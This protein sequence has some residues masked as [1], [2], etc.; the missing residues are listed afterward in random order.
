MVLQSNWKAD[1]ISKDH[2]THLSVTGLAGL[3]VHVCTHSVIIPLV[4]KH[5]TVEFE[6]SP[7]QCVSWFR[8]PFCWWLNGWMYSTREDLHAERWVCVCGVYMCV[9]VKWLQPGPVDVTRDDVLNC[10]IF[11]FVDVAAVFHLFPPE[12]LDQLLLLPLVLMR[13]R[14][15]RTHTQSSFKIY[16]TV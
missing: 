8:I 13:W 1:K 2:Q 14:L 15:R 9:C 3:S 16:S 11:A 10:S 12:L 7:S 4:L 5:L 6:R